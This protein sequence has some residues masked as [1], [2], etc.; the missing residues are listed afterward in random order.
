M[1]ELPDGSKT[2]FNVPAAIDAAD[3]L[4]YYSFDLGGY[5]VEQLLGHW[6]T[7]Y[8]ADW[9]RLAVIEALYQGRY[10]AISVE[11]ILVLWQRRQQAFCHFNREFER[12]VCHRIPHQLH[13]AARP[14]VSSQTKASERDLPAYP[15]P[16][17]AVLHLPS[18]QPISLLQAPTKIPP[19]RITPTANGSSASRLLNLVSPTQA[20]SQ[21]LP[22]FPVDHIDQPTGDPDRTPCRP[23]TE[24][25]TLV[26]QSSPE[27]PPLPPQP[28]PTPATPKVIPP[29]PVPAEPPEPQPVTPPPPISAAVQPSA[30]EP[31]APELPQPKSPVSA[32]Q[33]PSVPEPPAPEPPQPTLPASALPESHPHPPTVTQAANPFASFAKK[34]A[35]PESSVVQFA[36]RRSSDS[37]RPDPASEVASPEPASP[38]PH[39][40]QTQKEVELP[41]W[42]RIQSDPMLTNQLTNPHDAEATIAPESDQDEQA[43]PASN[44]CQPLNDN[45]LAPTQNGKERLLNQIRQG[46][47]FSLNLG[48]TDRSM[49]PKLRLLLSQMYPP[50]WTMFDFSQPIHQ[51][52]PAADSPDFHG[53]LRAVAQSTDT[54]PIVAAGEETPMPSAIEQNPLVSDR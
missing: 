21:P 10:K 48:L 39:Q 38:P 16:R 26:T 12:L 53:K 2:S 6:L 25:R 8:A 52:V 7:Q 50:D 45:S 43:I 32:L 42:K 41:I 3:L 24:L 40:A 35:T 33:Q 9:I 13:L 4:R 44:H 31:P 37:T 30:P 49:P 19:L 47:R 20:A 51:F 34:L 18:P 27:L 15:S 46:I 36:T 22:P 5:P 17:K 14:A 11:Q 23:V 54:E 29:P 1:T 28:S